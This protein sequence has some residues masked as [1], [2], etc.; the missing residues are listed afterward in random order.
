M[1]KKISYFKEKQ[2]EKQAQ[3]EFDKLYS[4]TYAQNPIKEKFLAFQKAKKDIDVKD[5]Y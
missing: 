3:K 2:I 5:F 1:E 4:N